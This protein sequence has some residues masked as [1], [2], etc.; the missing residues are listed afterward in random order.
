MKQIAE[1]LQNQTAPQAS[2]V[3]CAACR[4]AREV[5]AASELRFCLL[6]NGKMK[7]AELARHCSEFEA[8]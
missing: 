3:H 1:F 2:L 6:P 7:N 4:H 8:K 5:R